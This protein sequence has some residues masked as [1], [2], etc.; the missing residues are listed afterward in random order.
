[1]VTQKQEVVDQ[2]KTTEWNETSENGTKLRVVQQTNIYTDSTRLI[3][4]VRMNA[5][6]TDEVVESKKE[7]L[8]AGELYYGII[9]MVLIQVVLVT[10]V[11]GPIAAFLVEIFP[12]RIRYTS[13]SLPYHIGNGVFGRLTPFIATA[14]Y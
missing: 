8:L 12:T 13:M 2:R 9:G 4:T 6:N 1:D 7:I 3:S 11:Y 10:M 5:A 14:L